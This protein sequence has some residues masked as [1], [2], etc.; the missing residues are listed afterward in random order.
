MKYIQTC[1]R[2]LRLDIAWILVPHLPEKWRFLLTKYLF[3]SASVF[4][5]DS[6]SQSFIIPGWSHITRISAAQSIAHIQS[7]FIDHEYLRNFVP[8]NGIIIDVGAHIGEFALMARTL[9]A[10]KRIISIEPNPEAF[11]LLERNNNDEHHNIAINT[12]ASLLL[13]ID[14]Q[15]GM[16]SKF[17][18]PNIVRKIPVPCTTLD[19]IPS[20]QSLKIIDLLK[21]DVEGMEA[22]VIQSSPNTIRKSR[23][24]T[25]ELTI[26][27]IGHRTALQTL[28]LLRKISP[29]ITLL[30]IGST[31][32][33][34]DTKSQAAVDIVFQNIPS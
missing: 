7:I 11:A 30:H 9:L 8:S 21:I 22:Q 33:E 20:I 10:P 5:H 31:I 13:H 28:E 14:E 26:N 25:I 4:F 24:I 34:E 27:R 2:S 6:K 23:I 32:I 19:E 1:I 3:I 18:T 15:S 17:P 12:E 29:N 16:S